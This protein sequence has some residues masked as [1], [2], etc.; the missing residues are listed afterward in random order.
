MENITWDPILLLM[1]TIPGFFLVWSFSKTSGKK[2]ESDFEY[3][4]FSVFWGV[5][6][7]GLVGHGNEKWISKLFENIFTGMTVL[8]LI[9]LMSG[10]VVSKVTT[11]YY[12][13]VKKHFILLP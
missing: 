10:W 6:L 4:M 8:S 11:K 1:F 9:A 5:I 3:L 12:K 13:K 7:L 2:I